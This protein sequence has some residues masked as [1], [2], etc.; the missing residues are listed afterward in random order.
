MKLLT[1]EETASRLGVKSTSLADKRYRFRIGLP[2][3][4]VG[5]RI[6][7]SETDVEKLITR[8]REKLPAGSGGMHG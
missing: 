5:R 7:F 4:K 3:V 1:L 2:A 6:G 8:G